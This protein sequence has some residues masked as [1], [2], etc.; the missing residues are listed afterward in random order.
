MA[1]STVDIDQVPPDIDPLAVGVILNP[2]EEAFTHQFAGKDVT[3]PAA[4]YEVEEGE[5]AGEGEAKKGKKKGKLVY[6]RVQYPLPVCVHIAKHLAEK[7]I[8]A[9]FRAGIEAI[10]DEKLR[11]EKSRKA[12]PDAKGRIF[13]KMK[14]LVETDS[15]FFETEGRK[16]QFIR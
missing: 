8:R 14:E 5:E 7:I 13:E 15:D 11:D 2:L 3:V 10:K 9:E 12:I 1:E 16:E 4:H 6:G